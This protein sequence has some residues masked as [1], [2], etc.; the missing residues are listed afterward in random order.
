[1]HTLVLFVIKLNKSFTTVTK[2]YKLDELHLK[3]DAQQI[4]K[5]RLL[6]SL[7]GVRFWIFTIFLSKKYRIHD[8]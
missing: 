4:L 1:M 2:L 6:Y 7:S 3:Q 8:I 5:H